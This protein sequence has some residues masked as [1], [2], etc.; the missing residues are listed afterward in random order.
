MQDSEARLDILRRR[1]E[2]AGPSIA[3]TSSLLD[4]HR[5]A[6]AKEKKKQDKQKLELDWPIKPSGDDKGKGREADAVALDGSKHINFWA[7]IEAEVS[8]VWLALRD[9]H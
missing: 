6:L 7:G 4:T 8:G 5:A 3:G 1:A 9:S 2:A